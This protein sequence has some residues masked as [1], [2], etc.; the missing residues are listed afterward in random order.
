MPLDLATLEFD[1]SAEFLVMKDYL[2]T[3][4]Q[5]CITTTP[6]YTC[7]LKCFAILLHD[8]PVLVEHTKIYEIVQGWTSRERVAENIAILGA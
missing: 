2:L 6:S 4:F 1:A 5:F 7:N 3:L 8:E